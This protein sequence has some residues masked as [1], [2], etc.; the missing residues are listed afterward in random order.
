MPARG[1]EGAEAFEIPLHHDPSQCRP[2]ALLQASD[3]YTGGWRKL[4]SGVEQLSEDH[5]VSAVQD[6]VNGALPES[7]PRTTQ[8]F[9]SVCEHRIGGK[10]AAVY[11]VLLQPAWNGHGCVIRGEFVAFR[12]S[13]LSTIIG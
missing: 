2:V 11:G 10:G 3:D 13:A 7:V 12:P 5:P 6:P 4:R 1:S 8:A 9:Q